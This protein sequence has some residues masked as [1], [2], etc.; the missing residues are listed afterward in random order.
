METLSDLRE[1]PLRIAPFPV[2]GR[3]LPYPNTSVRGSLRGPQWLALG[4][5]GGCAMGGEVTGGGGDRSG[6]GVVPFL[7]VLAMKRCPEQ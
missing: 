5:H 7:K 3:P 4:H 6:G 2:G 1:S